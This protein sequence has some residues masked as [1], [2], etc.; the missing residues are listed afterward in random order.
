LYYC[1]T[2]SSQLAKIFEAAHAIQ[3]RDRKGAASCG[4]RHF[5]FAATQQCGAVPAE[6]V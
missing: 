1:T 6:A 2:E 4:V 3:S 5:R